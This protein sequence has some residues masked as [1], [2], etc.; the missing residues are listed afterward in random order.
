MALTFEGREI[1]LD[2]RGYLIDPGAWDERL[3]T[4]LAALDGIALGDE[5]WAVLRF[6]RRYHAEFRMAPGM[7]LLLKALATELGPEWGTSRKLYRLFPDGPAR[8]ACRYAGL[9]KPVSC[10]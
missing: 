2:E 9:P 4:H 6:L 3:A 8:Q 10:I 5:H 1:A 7:R